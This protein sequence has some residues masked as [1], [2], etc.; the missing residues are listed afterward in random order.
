MKGI[1]Q[2]IQPAFQLN[3]FNFYMY[4]ITNGFKYPGII[5]EY[6]FDGLP[7]EEFCA[8]FEGKAHVVC[9]FQGVDGQIELGGPA[10]EFIG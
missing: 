9:H 5:A 7:F 6:S 8:V 2:D 4:V 10:A 3:I 1:C